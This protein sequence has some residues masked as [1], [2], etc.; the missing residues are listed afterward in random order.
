ML[1]DTTNLHVIEGWIN[2]TIQGKIFNI[3][4]KEIEWDSVQLFNKPKYVKEEDSATPDCV[5]S[6]NVSGEE[7]A[8]ETQSASKVPEA[9]NKVELS[10]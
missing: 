1:V 6:S 7:S 2:L 4:I 9:V 3:Y 5:E 8:R 10:G